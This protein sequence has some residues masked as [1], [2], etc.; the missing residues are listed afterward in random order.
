MYRALGAEPQLTPNALGVGTARDIRP[1]A[2][3]LGIGYVLPIL[4]TP[5]SSQAM[6]LRQEPKEMPPM[7]SRA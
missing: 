4:R 7:T 2:A 3:Y 5:S 6:L 1:W